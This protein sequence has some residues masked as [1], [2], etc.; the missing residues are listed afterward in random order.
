M[1]KIK[2]K[3]HSLSQDRRYMIFVGI[4]I[5]IIGLIALGAKGFAAFLAV[6]LGLFCLLVGYYGSDVK[7]GMEDFK[8]DVMEAKDVASAAAQKSVAVAK[9]SVSKVEDVAKK[10]SEKAPEKKSVT[11][12]K[13]PV[14]KK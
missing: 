13:K 3:L 9:D 1:E 12:A 2:A 14:A 7:K 8:H 10:V 6:V 5:I 4:A 11:S